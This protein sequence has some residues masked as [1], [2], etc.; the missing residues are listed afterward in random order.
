M[1]VPEER[2][3]DEKNA[4]SQAV[5]WRYCWH[6][7][8]HFPVTYTLTMLAWSV[9]HIAPML[10][11]LAIREIFNVLSNEATWGW[12]LWSLVALLVGLGLGNVILS[13]IALIPYTPF[14]V[15]VGGTMRINMLTQVLRRP[16]AQ[17]LPNSAGEA[18]SRFRGD[19]DHVTNFIA[20]WLVDSPGILV[21]GLFGLAVMFSISPPV[22]LGMLVPLIVVVF[23]VNYVRHYLQQFREASRA[24]AGRVTS[25]VGEM[26]G[27]IQALQVNHAETRVKR[28]F[29][30][31]NEVRRKAALKDEM[32]SELM[33]TAFNST[34][35]VSIGLM[36]LIAAQSMRTG[37][38]TVG[39]FA[40]FV[41]YLV[42]VTGSITLFGNMLAVTRQ[43]AVSLGR[44]IRLLQGASTDT[45]AEKSPLTM[46]GPLPEVPPLPP[47]EQTQLQEVRATGLRY[48]YPNSRQGID[49]IDLH[50]PRG[51]FTVITG[52]VGAGKTT[53]L[54]VLLGLLPHDSGK[55][56]WNG[57]PV[58]D[59]A[60]F[61]VP[62]RCA[63]TAQV[64]RLFSDS[65][66]NN[67]LLG[68]PAADADLQQA[69]HTAVMER[70]LPELDDGLE[71]MVGPRGVKLS[72]GQIQRAAAARMLLRQPELLVFDDLSS[73]L[74]VET[75]RV[76]WERVF[77]RAEA[78]CLVVS[79]RQAVLR[80]ADHII[81]LKDGRVDDAGQ[82]DALLARNAEMRYL[83]QSEED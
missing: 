38:F 66:R 57:H 44:M 22:T 77:A 60:D 26:F 65:L 28:R 67:L 58:E 68:L 27:S 35:E 81:V 34:V 25:F 10:P 52:R 41:A 18:I 54:R 24:A 42:P 5:F 62:P 73:A 72:G 63:Y 76:L 55:I 13:F 45:L 80:R 11:G 36:L 40:L 49:G 74:D 37:S 69:L 31:I 82:L 12:N 20:D 33:G 21:R 30:E 59:P 23:V 19:V 48:R 4:V 29:D 43:N 53:L 2:L 56:T 61:F 15:L 7:L 16:G 17:A 50:L 8:R 70:D 71:T 83:W 1:S 46:T 51:S 79:H 39:D 78:T 64:P 32:F 3:F 6:Y 9:I 75:E 47:R 14:R